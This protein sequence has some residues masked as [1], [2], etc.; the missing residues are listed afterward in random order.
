MKKKKSQNQD[1][2]RRFMKLHW[3]EQVLNVSVLSILLM[4]ATGVI[5]YIY[6]VTTTGLNL[7]WKRLKL[8]ANKPAEESASNAISQGLVRFR[9]NHS[10]VNDNYNAQMSSFNDVIGEGEY[11]SRIIQCEGCDSNTFEI[12]EPSDPKQFDSNHVYS[13]LVEYLIAGGNSELTSTISIERVCDNE[14]PEEYQNSCYEEMVCPKPY[15]S[16]NIDIVCQKSIF[17][18]DYGWGVECTFN[19]AAG[20]SRIS[21]DNKRQCQRNLASNMLFWS[22]EALSCIETTHCNAKKYFQIDETKCSSD[23][24]TQTY[25]TYENAEQACQSDHRCK[26]I[27]DENG[28]GQN[29][30][31][32]DAPSSWVAGE[33]SDCVWAK[34]SNRTTSPTACYQVPHENRQ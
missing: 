18:E 33:I 26:G 30:K 4:I 24:F 2:V 23:Q 13:K 15:H 20:N 22:G 11:D 34:L 5:A 14:T 32:C 27:F 10:S 17:G 7:E 28:N 3:S 9:V 19:C 8:E 12:Q 29:L 1:C 16:S 25:A 31:L 21:G 6:L